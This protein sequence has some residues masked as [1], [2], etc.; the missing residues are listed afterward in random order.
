MYKERHLYLQR[1]EV[2]YILENICRVL[3]W[4][5]LRLLESIKRKEY[6]APA[7]SK[8]RTSPLGLLCE[9]QG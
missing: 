9:Y 8:K 5:Y 3:V 6:G 1:K 7:K 2:N 4:I